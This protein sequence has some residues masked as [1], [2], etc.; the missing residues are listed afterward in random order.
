M[1]VLLSATMPI[2]SLLT[3]AGAEVPCAVQT[4][5]DFDTSTKIVNGVTTVTYA[6]DGPLIYKWSV[7]NFLFSRIFLYTNT[8]HAS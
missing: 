2:A 5:Q 6:A 1:L 4:A 3:V 8:G 7:G